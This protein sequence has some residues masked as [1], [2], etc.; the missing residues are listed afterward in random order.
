MD[1][2]ERTHLGDGAKEEKHP[3]GSVI[4]KQ[5]EEGDRFYMITEGELVATRVEEGI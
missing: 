2:Y 5:G 1:P 3:A 4:I